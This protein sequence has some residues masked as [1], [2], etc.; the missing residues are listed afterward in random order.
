MG[1]VSLHFATKNDI[2]ALCFV[3]EH[4]WS[5]QGEVIKAEPEKIHKRV[6]TGQI[7]TIAKINRQPVGSQFAFRMNWNGNLESLTTWDQLTSEGW[8][9][10]VHV[11]TGNTGF[12]I[13]VGVVPKFRG[14]GFSSNLVS[15]PQR[16]SQLL[17]IN[18]LKGLYSQGVKQAIACARIPMY[19]QKPKML[20]EEYCRLH[21]EDGQLFDAVL[22]FHKGLTAQILK[23]IDYAMNDLESLDGGCWVKYDLDVVFSA[24]PWNEVQ[25]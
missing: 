25:F 11:S 14:Q 6:E 9:D 7:V 1:T 20:V 15:S 13:G 19:N 4:A 21:R 8:T 16:I 18:T 3:E 23:P 22:R 2:K 5:L 10:K 17:I 24:S 12:L